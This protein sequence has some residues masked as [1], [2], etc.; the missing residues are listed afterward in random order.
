MLFV[1]L[2]LLFKYSVT[3][4][5]G[6]LFLT[7]SE[8][9]VHLSEDF[10]LTAHDR[11]RHR[12]AVT[13]PKNLN[14][15]APEQQGLFATRNF[16]VRHDDPDADDATGVDGQPSSTNSTKTA[17]SIGC[18][19]VLPYYVVKR[20]AGPLNL[21]ASEAHIVTESAAPARHQHHHQNHQHDNDEPEPEFAH[22]D[23]TNSERFY[24]R[25]LQDPDAEV[26]L[27]LHGNSNSRG[28]PH[29][30][31]MYQLLRRL[32]YHVITLDYRG[33]GD[34][35][36]AAPTEAGVVRDAIA[37]YEYVRRCTRA[38]VY[39]WGHSLGT[40]IATHMMSLLAQRG[41]AAPA[42][43][44]L[45]S[46]FNNMDAEIRSHPMSRLFRNLPWFDY[47]IA[48]PL[49]SNRLRFESDEHI[50]EFRQPVMILHAE[51]DMVIPFELGYKVSGV[52]TALNCKK[53]L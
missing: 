31:E 24:E 21:T 19:H 7:F 40:G 30:I 32:G 44:V 38:P 6:I 18:W 33:Y 37:V 35:V 10:L 52:G 25:T 20:Y 12:H 53:L 34:S 1:V 9:F 15:S 11:H 22:I 50:A 3:L 36:G 13:Y 43:V 23:A 29:R 14:F 45:E 46:P 28:A 27:Y 8:L 47:M 48:R 39:V 49:Y 16:L 51:D 2:P 41:R 42:A 5:R 26:V 17:V 4:Q